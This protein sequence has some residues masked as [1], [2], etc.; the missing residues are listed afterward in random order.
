MYTVIAALS[1]ALL[2]T[3][4][5]LPGW[6]QLQAEGAADQ[7][8]FQ[9]MMGNEDVSPNFDFNEVI[10]KGM[11]SSDRMHTRPDRP[12]DATEGHDC[13]RIQPVPRHLTFITR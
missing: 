3:T 13:D 4:S 2:V 11:F 5:P 10:M 8:N 9:I 12:G 7:F 1:L 6:D